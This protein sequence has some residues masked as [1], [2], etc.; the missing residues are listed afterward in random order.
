[1]DE[2]KKPQGAP[3]PLPISDEKESLLTNTEDTFDVAK[4]TNDSVGTIVTDKR[5]TRQ[6]FLGVI[7]GAAS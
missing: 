1:M 6:S 5:R 3:S 4:A 2:Q 7:S